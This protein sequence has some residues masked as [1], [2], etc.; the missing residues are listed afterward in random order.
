MSVP[1]Q[2]SSKESI[3][4]MKGGLVR[5]FGL[6]FMVVSVTIMSFILFSVYTATGGVLTPKRVLTVLSTFI[7][8]RLT[9][10][11]FMVQ[12]ALAISEGLVAISRIGVS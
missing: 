4:I 8:L 9:S 6:A 12:N 7:V 3:I 2:Q 1:P 10:V 11:H 5:A